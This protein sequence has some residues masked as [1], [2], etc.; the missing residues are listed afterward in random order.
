MAEPG[1]PT[2]TS[3]RRTLDRRLCLQEWLRIDPDPERLIATGRLIAALFA[4][5]AIY[6]DPTRPARSLGEA[7]FVLGAYIA[8]SLWLALGT[9]QYGLSSRIHLFSH[10]VDVLAL[11]L[12]VYFTD[13]LAS[14]FFPFLPFLLLATTLRWGMRGAVL[15]A[16]VMEV[17]LFAV[18]WQ[19]LRDGESELNLLI[20]R[21]AYFLIAAVMLGYFGAT[22][23]RSSHRFAQLAAWSFAPATAD[24]NAWLREMM[25]HA[26]RLLGVERLLLLWQDQKGAGGMLV[27]RGPDGL[28]LCDI[29]DPFFWQARAASLTQDEMPRKAQLAEL[30]A[31]ATAAGWRELMTPMGNLRSAPFNGASR[32][33]LFVLNARERNEDA[34]P[35]TKITAERI[36]HELERW[37]LVRAIADNARDQERV[38]LA[39]DLHDSVL[40]DLTAASLKLK[41]V[42]LMVPECARESLNSVSRMMTEQQRKIRL[43]VESSRKLEVAPPPL[44]S[45]SLS[46]SVNDLCDQW[47]CEILLSLDPPDLETPGSVSREL[48]QLLCEATANAV[49][50]GGATRLTVEL[51]RQQDGV[52]M[53]I[54][55][56]GCGI[57]IPSTG[58]PPSPRSLQARIRDLDGSLAITR[59]NPGLALTI[60]VPCP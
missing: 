60:E 1:D 43:F 35:L 22:R 29:E 46:Q 50:H 10:G 53:V 49:R 21:S 17:L 3:L 48:T 40:Q 45:C 5:L 39:R 19:D 59:Y 24:R 27:L 34:G 4:A 28:R 14:P 23:A 13:E 36:G 18:G 56:N 12:L 20:M 54:T 38:R 31:I 8:F 33:R 25:D 6:L 58:S 47:G 26:S 11:A 37:S 42:G 30:G 51:R 9:R 52:Q 16:L 2:R 32:G 7:H 55:D 44:L 57:T 15:G 41:T